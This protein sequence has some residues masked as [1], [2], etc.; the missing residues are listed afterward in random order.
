MG[1]RD[2]FDPYYD[3]EPDEPVTEDC[4]DKNHSECFGMNHE[5]ATDCSCPCHVPLKPSTIGR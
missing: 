3:D 1:V 2:L 4:A 5:T